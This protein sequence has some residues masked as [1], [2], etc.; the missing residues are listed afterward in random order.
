MFK[1]LDERIEEEIITGSVSD[2]FFGVGP[3][4]EAHL[5]SSRANLAMA[6]PVFHAM[7]FGPQWHKEA[8]RPFHTNE[9]WDQ[10][11]NH[12]SSA[13]SSPKSRTTAPVDT[14]D[15][16]SLRTYVTEQL[17]FR[18]G[19]HHYVAVPDIEPTAFQCMLRYVHHLDPLLSLDN[20]MQVYRAADKYQIFGLLEACGTFI[21]KTVDP[22]NVTQV[23]V[24]F[25]VACRMG[26][27]RYS[28]SFLK[29]LEQLSRVQ[30]RQVLQA[31]E[32]LE[33][34]SVSLATL[35][36]SDGL[37]VNE[38]LLWS[39]IRSW[40]EVRAK[41]K[42]QSAEPE[43][44]G[45]VADKLAAVAASELVPSWQD[46]IRPL[47]HLIR[48]PAMSAAFFAK[49]I[50]KSGVLSHQEVVEIFGFL[51]Q[52]A[53]TASLADIESVSD[54]DDDVRV[55]GVYRADSRI[56][57]L[58]W[59]MAPGQS[60]PML[61]EEFGLTEG[62]E[63]LTTV[64]SV[65]VDGRGLSAYSWGS[66]VIL[67]GPGPSFHLAFGTRGFSSG[68]HAWTISWRP[69]DSLQPGLGRSRCSRGGAAGI[70]RDIDGLSDTAR[71]AVE[72]VGS[73]SVVSGTGSGT[74]AAAANAGLT[75]A[76][77]TAAVTVPLSRG[78]V[79]L[80]ASMAAG[81]S[82]GSG[83]EEPSARFLDWPSCIVFGVKRDV[84]TEGRYVAWEEDLSSTD[85]IRFSI[86]L[87]FPSRTITYIADRGGRC[88]SAAM[89]HEGP[90]YPVIAASGPHFFSIQYG[91][92]V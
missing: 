30:T 32:F 74:G 75:P 33:L 41:Y 8:G 11:G 39:A 91:C 40:A 46:A 35:L 88:W 19:Q 47:R 86:V 16:C 15:K 81:A 70:A 4:E 52:K 31:K 89:T 51:A 26:L 23:L 54:E 66:S 42:E 12:T 59:C 29:I 6:S 63:L 61:R 22:S 77:K 34:H 45:P 9:R 90:V 83:T 7:F 36:G 14:L 49:E 71:P 43:A 5:F 27:E 69:M 24:L 20:A 17:Q 60:D 48:F 21:E 78:S 64:G 73:A 92:H 37:C 2:V 28:Q 1:A 57:R 67:A 72:R 3:N 76:A 62:R 10:D 25:D 55:G 56:P 79:P 85:V 82:P 44:T 58:G 38:E 18:P 50:S 13:P 84:V 65:V 87:D 53:E 68:R 80:P